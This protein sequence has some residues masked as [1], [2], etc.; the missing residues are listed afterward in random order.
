[1]EIKKLMIQTK[2]I[3]LLKILKLK[4]LEKNG[5]EILHIFIQKKQ[6]GLI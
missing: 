3:Y 5:L 6:V 2:K 1:M 4:S